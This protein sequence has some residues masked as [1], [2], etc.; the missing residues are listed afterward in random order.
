MPALIHPSWPKLSRRLLVTAGVFLGAF[1]IVTIL[2]KLGAFGSFNLRLTHALQARGS[3][4]QDIAL[5]IFGYLG[6]IEVTLVVGIF[7]G[8]ALFRGLRLLAVLPAAV[9]STWARRRSSAT[10]RARPSTGFPTSCRRSATR[11]RPTPIRV[12]IC[13]AQR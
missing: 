11:S 7:L 5:G 4:G 1:L 2:V 9:S 3:T 10:G 12:A 13:C 8:V 6:S